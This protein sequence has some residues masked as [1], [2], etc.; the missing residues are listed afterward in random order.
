MIGV[1]CLCYYRQS[2]E[3]QVCFH[4]AALPDF[5]EPLLCATIHVPLTFTYAL[6]P[7]DDHQ[8]GPHTHSLLQAS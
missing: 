8:P 7:F 1:K 3:Q 5:T 4:K 6:Q 2:A